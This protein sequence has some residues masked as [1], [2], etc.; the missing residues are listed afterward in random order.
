MAQGNDIEQLGDSFWAGLAGR[1]LHPA[2]MEIV[3]ALRWIGRPLAATDLLGVFEGQR[4]GSRLERRLRQ[5]TRLDAIAP[6]DKG[7]AH[8]RLS[9]IPYRL[10]RARKA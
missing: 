1:V 2:H 9:Q 6:D 5:L 8:G 3:E 10:K 4:A 7:K